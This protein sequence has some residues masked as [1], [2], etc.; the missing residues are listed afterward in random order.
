MRL[1][2]FLPLWDS[3]PHLDLIVDALNN[4][5]VHIDFKPLYQCIHIYDALDARAE[6][7]RNYQEDRKVIICSSPIIYL[8]P[9]VHR[10]LSHISFDISLC[11]FFRPKPSSSCL[12][13]LRQHPQPFYRPCP[14][15]WKNSSVSSS[16][17]RP[18]SVRRTTFAQKETSTTSGMICVA[19]LLKL[20]RMDS[21]LA[22]TSMCSWALRR[23]CSCSFRHLR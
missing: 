2:L 10:Y 23:R 15:L 8:A 13:E 21:R 22:W 18:F 4:D 12:N 20:S 1:N 16:S 6:L 7:Q 5:H 14:H 9:S 19:R 3:H 11:L 17:N